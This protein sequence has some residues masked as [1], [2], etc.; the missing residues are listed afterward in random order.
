VII[1]L[2]E[3][4]RSNTPLTDAEQRYYA[5][6]KEDEIMRIERILVGAPPVPVKLRDYQ[7]AA[8]EGLRAQIRG[9]KRRVVLVSPTGSGK[10]C[11][12]S[13]LVR[14]AVSR[15]NAVLFIAHRR[16]LI[17][18]AVDK[19]HSFGVDAGVIMADDPR[20]DAAK[21][22]Q[23]A[24]IQTLGRRMDRLPPA[25]LIIVDECHRSTAPMYRRVLDAYA[26]ATV[27]GLTAT[28]WPSAQSHLASLYGASV[29]AATPAQLIE[30]GALCRYEAHA[31]FSPDLTRAKLRLGDYRDEDLEDI[32][33]TDVLV[34]SCVEEYHRHTPGRR[35]VVF[36][37]SIKHSLRLVA[38][39]RSI[40]YSAEHVD[41]ET[42]SEQR[43]DVMERFRRGDITVLSSVA[44]ISEGFDAPAAEVAI[45]A[46]PT[47]SLTLHLQQIGR[48][49]RP[50][51]DTG[52]VIARIH[53]HAGNLLRLGLPDDER[54]YSLD[55]KPVRER[56]PRQCPACLGVFDRP[57]ADGTC[58]ICGE[59]IQIA[60]A[61]DDDESLG[62]REEPSL[63]AVQATQ[64]MSIDEIRA[65]REERGLTR[66]LTDRQ[67]LRAQRATREEKA[68]EYLRLRAVAASKGFKPGFV[69]HQYRE[70]FGV[71]PKFSDDDLA[72][73]EP[74]ARP[75][76][77]LPPRSR[78]E[79]Q[80]R[81]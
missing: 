68:A 80:P 75:F 12:A 9:G 76:F 26:D 62:L 56:Q 20:T 78:N 28:P 66:S 1:R 7:L 74:A 32:C 31:Y 42:P 54:D 38:E 73:I 8:I 60:A 72:G 67:L 59:L 69:S 34:G 35:A 43:R 71:W 46:R 19:L 5:L 57:R 70:T 79:R 17:D 48:V 47:K 3:K 18:Q 24:S 52:K 45:L 53:D 21:P 36:P 14:L 22:V 41:G 63:R 30:S 58:P 49:L 81:D 40:G 11:M 4:L 2:A 61:Q 50:S 64:R 37:V 15:G 13:E 16:E 44:V 29:V 55:A 39:F 77:P 51:P 23:V 25:Q 6:L 27:I 33:N 65:W 10:T